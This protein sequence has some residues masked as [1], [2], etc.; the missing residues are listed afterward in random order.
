MVAA[1]TF[2]NSLA[3]ICLGGSSEI[4]VVSL[5]L[6]FTLVNSALTCE[7]GCVCS[8]NCPITSSSKSSLIF[9]LH[10]P[11]LL[12]RIHTCGLHL[13]GLFERRI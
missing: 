3:M 8:F 10:W 4:L 2:V 7:G 13:Q 1:D 12:P 5:I 11:F 9:A 6:S